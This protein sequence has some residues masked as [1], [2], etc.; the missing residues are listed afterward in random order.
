MVKLTEKR[1][2]SIVKKVI[3][4]T[5]NINMSVVNGMT[6][7]TIKSVTARKKNIQGENVDIM[8]IT[9]DNDE[10]IEIRSAYFPTTKESGLEV[11]FAGNIDGGLAREKYEDD[12]YEDEV[13]PRFRN[14]HQ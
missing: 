12:E 9:L 1:L 5:T 11:D 2:R 14:R 7:K 4:E 13:I 10:V 3:N 8:L 6:G